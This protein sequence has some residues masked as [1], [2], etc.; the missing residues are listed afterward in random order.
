MAGCRTFPDEESLFAK[1]RELGKELCQCIREK[2]HFPEQD[3]YRDA[4][5]ARMKRL[6]E[7]RQKDWIYEYEYWQSRK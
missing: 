6:V 3:A 7:Y 4:F 1:A 2:K 5:K